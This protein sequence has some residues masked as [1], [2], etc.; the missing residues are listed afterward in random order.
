MG[1]TQLQCPCPRLY[2]RSLECNLRDLHVC[3]GEEAHSTFTKLLAAFHS[4]VTEEQRECASSAASALLVLNAAA[5]S[6]NCGTC[7]TCRECS[8]EVIEADSCT[9]SC[10]IGC[11]GG[12]ALRLPLRLGGTRMTL[13]GAVEGAGRAW[14]ESVIS[15]GFSSRDRESGA[16]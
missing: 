4:Q 6:S 10:V 2:C 11:T 1:S 13:M 16:T 15:A 3:Q 8:I 7:T 5:C 12:G 14:A 9:S